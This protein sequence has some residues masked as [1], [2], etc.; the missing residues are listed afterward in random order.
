MMSWGTYVFD[1]STLVLEGV[2]LG[3][4]VQLVVEVLIDLSGGTV[5]DEETAEDSETAHPED[6]AVDTRVSRHSQQVV[7]Q[8]SCP[9]TSPPILLVML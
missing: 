7:R 4:E 6:L 5:L 9:S 8:S 2:T 1:E 3:E